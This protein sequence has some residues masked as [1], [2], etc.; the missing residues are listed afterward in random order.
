MSHKTFQSKHRFHLTKSSLPDK[1]T[2]N[3]TKK[4]GRKDLRL[5]AS[6]RNTMNAVIVS[7]DACCSGTHSCKMVLGGKKYRN[8]LTDFARAF[9]NDHNNILDAVQQIS[10]LV[11]QVM[12][13]HSAK[14]NFDVHGGIYSAN[15]FPS[16]IICINPFSQ[17][18]KSISSER[19]FFF[20]SKF[21][22]SIT[23]FWCNTSK[24]AL[25]QGDGNIYWF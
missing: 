9:Q 14:C 20:L 10:P 2:L 15:A 8:T 3:I 24:C 16:P 22:V 4:S 12:P 7:V 18:T 25:K 5:R 1:L 13:S 19:T 17:K 11:S 6:R 21:G 23:R